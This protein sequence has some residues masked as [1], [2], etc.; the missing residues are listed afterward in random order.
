MSL[1]DWLRDKIEEL[2]E[3]HGVVA[4]SVI[5]NPALYVRIFKEAVASTPVNITGSSLMQ[6]APRSLTITTSVGPVRILSGHSQQFGTIRMVPTE[7][8]A[9]VP[10]G[11]QGE[12]PAVLQEEP[13]NTEAP[14][15]VVEAQEEEKPKKRRRKPRFTWE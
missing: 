5:V 15:S 14:M 1:L 10:V 11:F 3:K 6:S 9:P 2:H 13:F 7:A 4:E 12:L 8:Y